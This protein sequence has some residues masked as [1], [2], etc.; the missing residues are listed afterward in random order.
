M[1]QAPFT[2]VGALRPQRNVFNLTHRKN[3][4]GRM[5]ALYPVCLMECVPGDTFKVG[6][7]VVV[8]LQP[9]QAPIMHDI[10][11]NIHYFFVPFRILQDM[12]SYS[13]T[14]S[15]ITGGS[16]AWPKPSN[17]NRL[18]NNY[19]DTNSLFERFIQQGQYDYATLPLTLQYYDDIYNG[20][21]AAHINAYRIHTLWDHFG[22]PPVSP[23]TA[24]DGTFT[25]L[26]ELRGRK[27]LMWP[28]LAYNRIFN[29]YYLDADLQQPVDPYNYSVLNRNWRKDYFTCARPA[30]LR[31]QAPAMPVNIGFDPSKLG[32]NNYTSLGLV[33]NGTLSSGLTV[34]TAVAMP[35]PN[36]SQSPVQYAGIVSGGVPANSGLAVSNNLIGSAVNDGLTTQSFNISDLRLAFQ[37]QK[38]L[39][40]NMRAGQRYTEFLAAHFGYSPRDE[41]LD[42]PEYIGG[43]STPIVISEVLQTSQTTQADTP[44]GASAQ[45]NMSGHG[46]TADGNF[47]G[48]YNVTEFGLIMGILSVM[49][50][51]SYQDGISRCWTRRLP[52]DYY[53][54]E[55]CRL[56][57]QAI[58]G[59]E[60]YYDWSSAHNAAAPAAPLD[61]YNVKP[62][63]FNGQYD[64]LRVMQD[65]VSSDMRR[66][67]DSTKSQGIDYRQSFW[68]LSRKFYSN[69]KPNL[70]SEFITCVPRTDVFL[71]GNAVDPMIINVTNHVHATRPLPVIADPGLVDHF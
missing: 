62:W 31:G 71:T 61:D 66:L 70:N 20:S 16:S 38:W 32:N 45:G 63:G 40:R 37:L 53:F 18:I 9:M 27:V 22:F 34:N 6:A 36:S 64:E 67:E 8:R 57:E 46:L 42:R 24:P 26:N 47:V 3:F 15:I 28:W 29:D 17:T 13:A 23:G 5:G 58:L 10:K 65:Y 60:L 1:A 54:P 21:N 59:Q 7:D 69:N 41:R 14:N 4:T 51:P 52:S 30:R 50:K 33:I 19:K 44:N 11:C 68:N 56:S 35:N 25:A 39:E 2:H 49:P 43:L 48:Q 12:S 55:F